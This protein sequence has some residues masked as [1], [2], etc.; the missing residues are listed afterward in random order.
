M[1]HL[2][3][4]VILLWG[5]RRALT[6]FLAGAV[7]AFA[8]PPFDFFAVG[9]VSFPVLVWLL[10]GS[11]EA[12]G[13][14]WLKRILRPFPIGWWFGFGY[15]VAGLWWIGNALLVEAE[16]FAWALPFAVFGL[17]AVLAVF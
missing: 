13:E 2:A 11:T 16:L 6:A 5:W 17:P 7:A 4:R 12:P 15:F 14:R 1:E 9:F 8:Q 3:G 10:D